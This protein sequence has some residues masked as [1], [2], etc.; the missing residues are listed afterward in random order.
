MTRYLVTLATGLCAASL[1]GSA[2]AA[3]PDPS[4]FSWPPTLVAPALDI[5]LPPVPPPPVRK[6][7][8]AP[9]VV[10]TPR[11]DRVLRAAPV[12]MTPCPASAL[13]A[14]ARQARLGAP[15]RQAVDG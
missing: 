12:T 10:V 14:S 13:R 4:L 2:M 11:G 3:V 15:A 1:V 6:A 8:P 9:P 7:D 5:D